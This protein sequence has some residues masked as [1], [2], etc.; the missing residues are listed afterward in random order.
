MSQSALHERNRELLS[1]AKSGDT[2]AET[3]LL[4]ENAGLLRSV[5]R[6]FLGRGTDEEDLIQIGTIGMLRAIRSFD[7]DRG[8]LFST[9][10]V[11]LILG[12]LRRHFRDSG[13][14]KIS[15]LWKQKSLQLL[16]AREKIEAAEGRD[17]TLSEL[18]R[19]CSMEP[20][21]AAM[22]LQS[23]SPVTFFS[24]PLANDESLTYETLLADEGSLAELERVSDALAI[25]QCLKKMPSEW[26]KIVLLRYYRDL[27]Q[28]E[29]AAIL[30]LTQVKVSRE[31][32]K[33]LAFFKKELL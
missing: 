29:T 20:E 11:P 23:L 21:E 27:T 33:I 24:E 31:E 8:T 10:A 2:E 32:K 14:V 15:R 9:Y 18:A 6:R 12:E 4:E 30:G 13:P 19:E 17:A 22:A 28:R 7:P 5:V 3:K 26:R 16:R 25:S 1:A